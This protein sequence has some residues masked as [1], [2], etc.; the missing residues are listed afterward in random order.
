MRTDRDD[1]Q[2]ALDTGHEGLVLD[3]E[4]GKLKYK[5]VFDEEY[6][7]ID[8]VEGKEGERL[9]QMW[10]E[11]SVQLKQNSNKSRKRLLLTTIS[12]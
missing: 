6:T 7:I 1:N 3:T 9:R 8:I 4:F 12:Q 10:K 11:F 5:P 2:E